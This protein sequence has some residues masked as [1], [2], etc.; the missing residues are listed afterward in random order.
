LVKDTAITERIRI[1]F[2]SEFFNIF[3]QHT[4]APPGGNQVLGSPAFGVSTATVLPERQIQFG[5][6]L[7][8]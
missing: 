2:R 3:N 7:I 5:L 4:F 8:F 6:R 1:Q